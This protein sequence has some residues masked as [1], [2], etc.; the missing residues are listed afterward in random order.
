MGSKKHFHPTVG[1]VD[2]T[3]LS[4]AEKLS[5]MH[6]NMETHCVMSTG[7]HLQTFMGK[8]KRENIIYEKFSPIFGFLKFLYL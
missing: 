6:A 1:V 2:R 4:H 3:Q 7:C 8:K 5:G